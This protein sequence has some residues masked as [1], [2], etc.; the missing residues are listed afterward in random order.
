[1]WA[2]VRTTGLIFL[3]LS[4]LRYHLAAAPPAEVIFVNFI[5][6]NGFRV[7]VPRFIKKQFTFGKTA[8]IV[9]AQGQFKKQIT[10]L[11]CQTTSLVKNVNGI[12]VT[13]PL[14][15]TIRDRVTESE[16]CT[17]QVS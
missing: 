10:V 5:Q 11:W 8:K 12:L 14:A 13:N 17:G 3:C 9:I 1:M 2:R 15:F 7:P 6:I 16:F 4:A